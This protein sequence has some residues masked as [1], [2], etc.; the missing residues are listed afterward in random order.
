M[1]LEDSS[2][3][4]HHVQ[5]KTCKVLLVSS[6]SQSPCLHQISNLL[7]EE[8]NRRGYFLCRPHYLPTRTLLRVFMS[9]SGPSFAITCLIPDILQSLPS[10]IPSGNLNHG[11]HQRIIHQTHRNSISGRGRRWLRLGNTDVERYRI[12]QF[13]QPAPPQQ[14]PFRILVSVHTVVDNPP[15][16]RQDI[17][18]AKCM[19]ISVILA[20]HEN[21]AISR[22]P[23]YG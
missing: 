14:T 17:C 22:F 7:V 4:L 11:V 13:L 20:A 10:P 1:E 3:P 2:E 15:C 5:T 21:E 16:W 18:N 8:H 23:T 9:A 19:S 12:S 6:Y